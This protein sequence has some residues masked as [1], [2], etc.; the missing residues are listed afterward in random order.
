MKKIGR[1][2]PC[3]CKSGL[4]YKFCHGD[5][6]KIEVVEHASDVIMTNMIQQECIKKGLICKHGVAKGEHCKDCKVD[7]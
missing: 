6:T 2:E 4:K 5:P 1:N 3:P 7:E